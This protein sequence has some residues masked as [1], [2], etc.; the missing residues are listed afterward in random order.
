MPIILLTLLLA[1][2]PTAA[3]PFAIEVVD[4]QTGLGV[5]LVEL[6][7]TGGI[8]FVTDSSGLVAFDEPGLMDQRVHF[9]VKSHGYEFRQ[10]GFGFRGVALDVAPGGSAQIKLKRLNIAERLYRVTGQGIYRDTV[11]LGRQPPTKRPV[12]NA[13]VIGSDSVMTVTYRDR[14][15]W[16]WGDTNQPGYPL[17]NF[18]TPGATSPLPAAGVLNP[19][20]GV[21]L[22]YFTGDDGFARPVAQM[23]GT[24]PTWINGV[25]VL[26]DDNGTERLLCGYAK[27]KPPLDV[28]GRGLALWNDKNAAFEHQME[29][30]PDAPLYPDGHTF[31][32]RERGEDYVYFTTSFPLVRTRATVES[33][34]NLGEY[35]AFTCLRPGTTL[36]QAQIDRDAA[37]RV[38]YAWKRGTTP[39]MPQDQARLVRE[40]KLHVHEGL[41]QL[42]DVATGKAV[43]AHQGSSAEWNERRQ[44]WTNIVLEYYGTSLLGE[45]WYA[46]ADSPLGPWVYATKVV[47]HDKYSFYNPQQHPTFNAADRRYLY[48]EGTY[49]HTF[50]GNEHRTP[51]YDY[52]QI[53]Y[54][55]DLDDERLA[56]PVAVYDAKGNGQASDLRMND[57]D[58]AAKAEF[59]KIAFFALDRPRQGTVAYSAVGN[60]LRDVPAPVDGLATPPSFYALAA[61]AAEPGI[62][63]PLYEYAGSA[64][65]PP[66]YDVRGDLKIEGYRRLPQPLCRVWP[67]PYQ[68]QVKVE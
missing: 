19:A 4:D 49:T 40:G 27:I 44:R 17:G 29:F 33:Y 2:D 35:E 24:G 45:I 1:A 34:L 50:S 64:G 60:A 46:E 68:P 30:A 61:D 11:L 13:Q 32:H 12:L 23:P 18:H 67:S 51:R 48:F 55:L 31:R 42:R 21:N 6:T 53:M 38:R 62:T 16:F 8:A 14:L 26:P 28:H 3:G 20:Q 10:D 15:F 43:L 66:R 9:L 52:N 39:V 41:L 54:R 57:V 63:L 5:P 7:T 36:S 59:G 37:G 56:L 25:A 22:E 47:T 58:S 65:A